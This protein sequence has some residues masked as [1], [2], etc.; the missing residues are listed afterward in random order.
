VFRRC[1]TPQRAL[2]PAP[3]NANAKDAEPKTQ[4]DHLIVRTVTTLLLDGLCVYACG[5]RSSRSRHA[6][7]ISRSAAQYHA[8]SN[9]PSSSGPEIVSGLISCSLRMRSNT[10]H[11]G[12]GSRRT[13]PR[14]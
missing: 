1:C 11:A 5:T 4:S 2:I 7:T 10:P 12:S 6:R 9:T 3:T 13:P 8:Y 14:T